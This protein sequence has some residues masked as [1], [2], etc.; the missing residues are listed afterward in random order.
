MAKKSLKEIKKIAKSLLVKAERHHL[1]IKKKASISA[2]SIKSIKIIE[3]SKNQLLHALGPNPPN[4]HTS[5]PIQA[6]FPHITISDIPRSFDP[7]IPRCLDSQ[8]TDSALHK[9]HDS[10]SR[11]YLSGLRLAKDLE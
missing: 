5:I 10:I 11:G 2:P 7:T 1:A 6:S 8:E 9:V 4:P 3:G